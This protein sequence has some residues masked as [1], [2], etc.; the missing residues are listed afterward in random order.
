[1]QEHKTNG[2]RDDS[3]I[4]PAHPLDG[5]MLHVSIARMDCTQ[6]ETC[7]RSFVTLPT[8]LCQVRTVDGGFGVG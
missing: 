7:P 6:R 8:S 4:E 2:E 5:R 3:E 1:V